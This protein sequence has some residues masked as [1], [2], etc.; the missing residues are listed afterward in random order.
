MKHHETRC[1]LLIQPVLF[2]FHMNAAVMIVL[3]FVCP[4]QTDCFNYIKILLRVNATHLY[5]CGT[6]AFSPTCAYIVSVFIHYARSK[7]ASI[8]FFFNL[9]FCAPHNL[10]YSRGR[11]KKKNLIHA[12][13]SLSAHLAVGPRLSRGAIQYT[14][15]VLFYYLLRRGGEWMK[16]FNAC[17][18]IRKESTR[19][20]DP[21]SCE[22]F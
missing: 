9:S 12:S 22:S 14:V 1:N 3:V 11:Q 20:R 13:S 5:A 19:F 18:Q 17:N 16:I 15:W 2:C 8:F 6:Y 10:F 7:T 4:L 21:F